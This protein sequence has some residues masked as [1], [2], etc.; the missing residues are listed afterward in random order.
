[1][2]DGVRVDRENDGVAILLL[3]RPDKANAFDDETLFTALPR[4]LE[5]LAADDEVR[6]LVVSGTGNA[7]CAGVDL[8]SA[9]FDVP[10][11]AASEALVR[12]AQQSIATLRRMPKPSI[13][14]VNGVA[15]GAGFGLAAG[16]DIR[17]V[18]PSAR[19]LAPF[20]RMGMVP[21]NGLSYTLPRIVGFSAALEILLTGR[22]VDAEEAVRIGLALRVEEDALGAA[23]E[24]ARLIAAGAPEAV[25]TARRNLYDGLHSSLEAIVLEAEPRSVGIAVH[26]AEFKEF[27]PRYMAE[28]EARRAARS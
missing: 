14:A 7:F 26:S 1:M 25:R 15:V 27:F 13:A 20:V 12:R 16:C 18:S 10:D 19:F 24:L 17:I 11:A 22:A 9:S 3:D 8:D 2:S 21:D 23:T 5:E 28:L 4:L 6:A